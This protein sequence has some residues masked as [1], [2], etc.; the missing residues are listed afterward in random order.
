MHNNTIENTHIVITQRGNQANWH[1]KYYPKVTDILTKYPSH[2]VEF[3]Q[4]DN[5]IFLHMIPETSLR[6]GR[7]LRM[8]QDGSAASTCPSNIPPGIYEMNTT[9]EFEDGKDLYEL[10]LVPETE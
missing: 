6:K 2:E 8:K 10:V 1:V 5:Q 9:P 7:N 4:E 3:I